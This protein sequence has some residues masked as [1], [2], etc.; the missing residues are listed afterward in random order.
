MPIINENFISDLDFIEDERNLKVNLMDSSFNSLKPIYSDFDIKLRS[1]YNNDRQEFLTTLTRQK[2]YSYSP[3]LNFTTDAVLRKKENE[4]IIFA[5][6]RSR[7]ISRLRNPLNINK[8]GL[9]LKY[10][11]GAFITENQY[12]RSL[13]SGGQRY[14][15]EIYVLLFSK[16]PSSKKRMA[17]LWHFDPLEH[18]L[19]LVKQG[20]SS[21]NLIEMTR[22]DQVYCLNASAL[23]FVTA[24]HKRVVP[25][26]RR[27]AEKLIL[28]ELGHLGQNLW[29]VSEILGLNFYPTSAIWERPFYKQFN[30]NPLK[31]KFLSM[32]VVSA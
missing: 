21:K 27:S 30:I 26:Y 20:I 1:K 10:S 22:S 7:R 9:L 32:F 3:K 31:E 8:L 19:K 28:T 2:R 6:R 24:I 11:A 12:L 5:K 13:P 23:I 4:L 15:L 16:K 17:N 14:P 25:K 18:N 29:L